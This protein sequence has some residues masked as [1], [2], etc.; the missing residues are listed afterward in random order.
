VLKILDKRHD[1]NPVQNTIQ[2]VAT[3]A[4]VDLELSCGSGEL[5]DITWKITAGKE[6]VAQKDAILGVPAVGI[7]AY[8]LDPAAH[9]FIP[10]P[11]TVHL[12]KPPVKL[13]DSLTE[14][15]LSFYLIR[16]GTY[17]VRV[18]ANQL[19]QASVT[20]HVV[21][22]DP[23]FVLP[24]EY[25]HVEVFK[26]RGTQNLGITGLSNP[27]APLF[28]GLHYTYN[29]T[30][31]RKAG[32]GGFGVVQLITWTKVITPVSSKSLTAVVPANSLDNCAYMPLTG[33]PDSDFAPLKDGK[34]HLEF[35][36][37]PY[38]P[39]LRHPSE[40]DKASYDVTLDTFLVFLP[41][42]G[43]RPSGVPVALGYTRMSFSARATSKSGGWQLDDDVQ[44]KPSYATSTYQNEV[45]FV[46]FPGQ[47]LNTVPTPCGPI[48]DDG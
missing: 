19:P 21:K 13:P 14:V 43:P 23:H 20:Y 36:D 9:R 27:Q 48:P 33:R 11:E 32:P 3:G 45:Q 38:I 8:V 28:G 29:P 40:G 37:G 44:P 6:N 24:P 5:T 47:Y 26:S 35:R 31:D 10:T 4:H 41:S 17:K 12:G 34:A 25:G 46:E 15:E 22:P 1:N 7:R 39:L 2:T 16:E 42:G 30:L 18:D